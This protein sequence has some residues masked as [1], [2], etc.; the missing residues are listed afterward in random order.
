MI[1]DELLTHRLERTQ[2]FSSEGEQAVILECTTCHGRSFVGYGPSPSEA[3][4]DARGAHDEWVGAGSPH[5]TPQGVQLL[6][7]KLGLSSGTRARSDP[8][9][10]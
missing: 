8:G 3:D 9:I 6:Y 5:S 1:K 10:P 2:H 7:R 4:D